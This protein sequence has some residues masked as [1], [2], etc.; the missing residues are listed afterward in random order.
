MG[1]EEDKED[2]TAEDEQIRT[3]KWILAAQK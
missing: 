3:L 2:E 1:L